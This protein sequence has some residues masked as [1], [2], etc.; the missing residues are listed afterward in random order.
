[1]SFRTRRRWLV[2]AA[3]CLAGCLSPTLPLPPPSDPTVSGADADGNV[4]LTGNVPPE[5]EVFALNHT[6]NVI[7][8]QLTPSGAYDFTIQAKQYDDLS[9]WY[10]KD[11]E[12]SPPTDVI[13]SKAPGA[14]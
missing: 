3:L 14:P 13:V 12:Q 11:T 8:G 5:S 9:V 2:G 10:V 1:M 4:R 6:T 7:G